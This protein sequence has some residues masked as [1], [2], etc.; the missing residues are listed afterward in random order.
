VG[1]LRGSE[2]PVDSIVVAT[3]SASAPIR[4]RAYYTCN[5]GGVCASAQKCPRE[6][7]NLIPVAS[8]PPVGALPKA[9]PS[10]RCKRP[11]RF[12]SAWIGGIRRSPPSSRAAGY[13]KTI[14]GGLGVPRYGRAGTPCARGAP[15]QTSTS[16]QLRQISASATYSRCSSGFRMLLWNQPAAWLEMTWRLFARA[17]S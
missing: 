13:L 9:W 7:S 8:M 3:P 12:F 5:S 4:G 11:L 17:N 16:A 2:S 10:G 6:P 15:S 14:F 1:G